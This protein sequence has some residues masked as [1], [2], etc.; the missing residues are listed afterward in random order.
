MIPVAKKDLNYLHFCTENIIKYIKPDKIVV[1]ANIETKDFVEKIGNL[2][3]CDEDTLL[4]GLTLARIKELIGSMLGTTERGGW[5]FQQ[6]LKLAYAYKSQHKHYLIWDS[7]NIP[8]NNIVFWN[9]EGKC[10]F[11][12]IPGY[13]NVPE[14]EII[15]K[16][17]CG[18]VKRPTEKSFIAE[19]MM[20]DRDCMLDMLAK[21]ENNKNLSGTNFYEKIVSAM[22]KN[23]TSFSE[24]EVYGSYAMTYYPDLYSIRKP[25][26]RHLREGAMV[27]EKG[28]LDY[29][30]LEWLS[31]NYD[32]V[33]FEYHHYGEA[34]KLLRPVFKFAARYRI[35]PFRL[36]LY[37]FWAFR[38]RSD[39]LNIIL[40]RL[41]VALWFW[42][43]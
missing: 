23:N 12:V 42:K 20:I 35:I 7:D 28:V 18:T 6:F 11:N 15:N 14:Y 37:C 40:K 17:F 36:C 10:L 30:T 2:E 38:L 33:T 41:T 39:L 21:I 25:K 9:N 8:L 16:L 26:L 31:K 43:R 24:F 34:P 4:E 32:S 29:K 5:F 27:V 3:F 19:H 1:V 22:D 13:Y